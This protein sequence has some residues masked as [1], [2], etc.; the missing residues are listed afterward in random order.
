MLTFLLG[1]VF[2]S[3]TNRTFLDPVRM[4]LC[5]SGQLWWIQ[6]GYG[7]NRGWPFDG[8][9]ILW[10]LAC[11]WLAQLFENGKVCCL[12]LENDSQWGT[13]YLVHSPSLYCIQLHFSHR[14]CAPECGITLLWGKLHILWCIA[15]ILDLTILLKMRLKDNYLMRW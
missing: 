7:W 4:W 10:W 14:Q 11:A 5:S 6:H 12:Y 15:D 3:C 1:T 2:E 9:V 13:P 8:S